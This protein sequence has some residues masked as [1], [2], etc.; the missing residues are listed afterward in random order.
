LRGRLAAGF[1]DVPRFDDDR[2]WHD[3]L[4][5]HGY[6][7]GDSGVGLGAS[8][9]TGWSG[10]GG[11][12]RRAAVA[13]P[14]KQSTVVTASDVVRDTLLAS[15]PRLGA[16]A[17]HGGVTFAVFSSVADAVEVCLF[18][19]AGRETRHGLRVQEG[20]VW[21][22]H[23]QGVLPGRRYGFRVHG[24][25]DPSR[26]LRCNPAKLLL[27]PYARSIDGDV[28]WHPAVYGYRAGAPD[29]REDTDSA[30]Y[31]PR[32][33][34]CATGFDWAGDRPPGIALVDSI[35][36]ELHVKG[37]T[38]L[39]PDIPQAL[40][41]NYAGLGHPVAIDHLLR[42]GVTAV[43]LL[44]V[45]Q[46]VHDAQL[47]ARGLRNYWGYQSIGFFAPHNEYASGSPNGGQVVEFKAMI[48]LHAAG[49]EGHPRRRL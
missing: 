5:F 7:R 34:V 40:R 41:G 10:L 16:H 33:V 20:S 18:D 26:G 12:P 36:Y 23:V 9:Q 30:P 15:R 25:W 49:L 48:K 11:R 21:A 42:L 31:V 4:L 22:A 19:D 45:H 6:F 3:A 27:D 44:P 13:C 1:G 24:P 39:H 47:V 37:F 35:V 14:R 32:S 17:D 38:K 29:Q 2:A 8:H 43:E 46:F 28:S